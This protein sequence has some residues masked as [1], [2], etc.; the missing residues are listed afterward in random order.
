[1]RLLNT[2]RY[3]TTARYTMIVQPLNHHRQTDSG[4]P[5]WNSAFNKGQDVKIISLILFMA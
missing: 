4:L 1:M 5:L 3:Y 2:Y